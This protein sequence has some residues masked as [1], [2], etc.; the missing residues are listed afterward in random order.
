M[1]NDQANIG[2]DSVTVLVS[3]GKEV[4]RAQRWMRVP[5]PN[6]RLVEP[7]Q[8]TPPTVIRMR[9]PA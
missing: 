9:C 2:K 7:V 8:I 6:Q 3:G 5:Q 1:V 4:G